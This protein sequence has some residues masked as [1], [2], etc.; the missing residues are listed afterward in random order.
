MRQAIG[1]RA[2]DLALAAQVWLIIAVQIAA[3]VAMM[4]Q[5]LGWLL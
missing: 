5:A 3:V 4:R 2:A 1:R